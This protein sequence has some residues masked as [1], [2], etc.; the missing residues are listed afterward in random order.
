MS[1][2]CCCKICYKRLHCG[3]CSWYSDMCEKDRSKCVHKKMHESFGD[4]KV[5]GD[6][7]DK[8]KPE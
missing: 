2:E 3:G 8:R 7:D 5:V 4:N 6:I 1:K